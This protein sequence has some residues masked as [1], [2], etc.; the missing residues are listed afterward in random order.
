MVS[1]SSTSHHQPVNYEASD[2]HNEQHD[3][4][5]GDIPAQLAEPWLSMAFAHRFSA[6]TASPRAA[7]RARVR[8]TMLLTL[9]SGKRTRYREQNEAING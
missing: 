2:S 5:G 7:S 8:L 6:S 9:P 1:S 4:G 3:R